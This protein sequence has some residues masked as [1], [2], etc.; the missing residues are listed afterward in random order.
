MNSIDIV[1]QAYLVGVRTPFV[2]EFMYLL[3]TI[4][5]LSLEFAIVVLCITVLVYLIK[6]KKYAILFPSALIAGGILTYFL[7]MFFNVSRPLDTLIAPFG[8]SFPSYHSVIATIFFGMLIYIF[9]DYLKKPW[10]VILNIFCVVMVILISFSR[11]Y[12]GV[13]WLSDVLGGI[14]LGILVIYVSVK[15]FKIVLK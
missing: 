5:D 3:T 10:R 8:Q 2:T 12:L 7:K 14:L 13:H 15:I 6:G 1:F 11:L 4:F 9:N